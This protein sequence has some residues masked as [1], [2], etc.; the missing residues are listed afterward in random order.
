MSLSSSALPFDDIRN[1]VRQMPGPDEEAIAEVRAREVQLTKPAGSLGRLES[2]AEWVAAWSGR[3]KPRITRPVVA[4]FAANHG[5]A[6]RGVSAFPA[7]VTRQMVENFSAGG[8]AINQLCIAHDLGL[9]VFDLALDLP[10][11]DIVEEDAFDEAN[12]AATMA[13]G[14]E[15]VSGGTDLLCIGEM[16]I[17]NTTV[18][19]AVLS[20][21]FGGTPGDWVGPGTGVDDDGMARKREAVEGAV[22]RIA[23]TR[24]PLEVLRRVGGREIAAMSGAVLAARLQRI[25]V[26]VDGFVATAAVAVLH[27]MDPSALDHCIFAH[28]SAES[29]HGR[30]LE[31]MG[32]EPLLDLGMRLGEGTGAALAAGIVKAAVSTHTGMATFADAGVAGKSPV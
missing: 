31:H 14:M 13:F 24:D 19:A 18:A 28:R 15:A 22:A 2:L 32:K 26:I 3:G 20:G 27:A 4:I 9:K 10:T 29:A 16:G 25:P 21:L 8:A 11:P 7:S 23:G 30:A 12:C 6:E 17:G 5:V 1:L